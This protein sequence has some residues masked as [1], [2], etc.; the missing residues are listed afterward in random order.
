MFVQFDPRQ[1]QQIGHET[2]HTV[3]LGGHDIQKTVTCLGIILGVALQ[4]LDKARQRGQW[5]AQFV[6]GIGQKVHAH[7][8]DPADIRLVAQAQKGQ[9]LV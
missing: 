5:R 7:T 2:A 3:G 8:L 6:T 4:R 1:R 9:S